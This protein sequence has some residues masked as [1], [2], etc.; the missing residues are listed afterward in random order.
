MFIQRDIRDTFGKIEKVYS[1]IA[2]VGARQAGKTTFLKDEAK[3]FKFQY[4]LFD[5]PD[6]RDLFEKDIKKFEIQYMPGWDIVIFDEVHYCKNAGRNLKYLAD[7]GYRIWLTSSSESIL[8]KNV[9]SFLVGRVSIIRLY[10][11]SLNEF[12]DARMQKEFNDEIL[13]RMIWEHCTY[14]GYPKVVL[15]QDVELKK[16][17]LRDLYDTMILKD[18]ANVFSIDDSVSLER[19]VKYLS[20]NQGN[21]LSY[22]QIGK[23]IGLSFETVKKYLDALQKSYIITLLQPFFKNKLKEITKQ[24]KVY[25]IDNGLRNVIIKD[26]SLDMGGKNFENYVLSELLKA[27][28]TVRHWRTKS[29]AEVDFIVEKEGEIIPIEVKLN[30]FGKVERS[31]SSFIREYKPKRA[32][33]VGYRINRKT[34]NLNGC[35]IEF[36][37]VFDLLRLL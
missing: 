8:A 12:L 31:L 6:I 14:G 7:K 4:L 18:V 9:L 30:P 5:D 23:E 13:K 26:F 35:K 36:V 2:L 11:F 21:L 33:I 16:T 27:G 17:I 24:P 28:L 25:F 37:N 32:F 29:K 1:V 34:I 10:P 3:K 22:D 19:F 20:L 15:N